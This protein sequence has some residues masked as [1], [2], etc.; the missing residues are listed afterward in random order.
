MEGKIKVAL[1][2]AGMFGGDVHARAYA[3][4]QKSGIAGLL[5]RVGLDKWA[6]DLAPIEFELVAIA[7]RSEA[8]AARA[9]DNYESWTARR[10]KAYHGETPWRDVIADFPDL[11]VMSVATPDNLHT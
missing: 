8:S 1:V 5:A 2:G 7:T 9:C 6:R 10:P 4:L 11:D 3:D